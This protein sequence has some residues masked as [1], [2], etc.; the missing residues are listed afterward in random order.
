[1]C[2][3]HA[4]L[5]SHFFLHAL[6]HSLQSLFRSLVN[7]LHALVHSLYSLVHSLVHLLH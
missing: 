1:L 5:L 2:S 7:L 3:Q 6:V 4:A